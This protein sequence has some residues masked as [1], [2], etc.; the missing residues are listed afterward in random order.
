MHLFKIFCAELGPVLEGIAFSETALLKAHH[1]LRNTKI[2]IHFK[3]ID[4][5]YDRMEYWGKLKDWQ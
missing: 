4:K 1:D 2:Y 5:N 3:S